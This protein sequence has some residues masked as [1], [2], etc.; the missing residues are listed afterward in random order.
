MGKRASRKDPALQ[1][2][3]RCKK[4]K[5]GAVP[6]A[7]P[8][9][10]LVIL[11]VPKADDGEA[12]GKA[13][14]VEESTID[15]KVERAL[16]NHFSALSWTR[17]LSLTVE[18][19]PLFDR[20][21][22]DWNAKPNGS[23]LGPDYW[24]NIYGKVLGAIEWEP[25]EPSSP[26]LSIAPGLLEG[27][28]LA[29]SRN[30]A[31]R[32]IHCLKTY[33]RCCE[34]ALNEV[35]LCGLLNGYARSVAKSCSLKPEYAVLVATYL[36]RSKVENEWPDYYIKANDILDVGLAAKYNQL[37]RD[38]LSRKAALKLHLDAFT[39][40][41]PHG[42]MLKILDCKD[43]KCDGL[44]HELMTLM[45]A[46]MTGNVAFGMAAAKVEAGMYSYDVDKKMQEFDPRSFTDDELV[47]KL[48]Q[49]LAALVD[50]KKADPSFKPKR[51]YDVVFLGTPFKKTNRDAPSEWEGKFTAAFKDFAVQQAVLA[52]TDDQGPCVALPWEIWAL[53]S[54]ASEHPG[55]P[56]NSRYL[57]ESINVREFLMALLESRQAV[58]FAQ[59]KD[60]VVKKEK[61]L[62]GLDPYWW[63]EQRWMLESC[64]NRIVERVT[65]EI[66]AILPEKEKHVD[67]SIAAN[68][69]H[70]LSLASHVVVANVFKAKARVCVAFGKH[71]ETYERRAPGQTE[72]ARRFYQSAV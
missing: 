14:V 52:G 29:H 32:Q 36:T 50:E 45:K 60:V 47:K 51:E 57:H 53:G 63:L 19:E 37:R 34:R 58:T 10:L 39:T 42:A 5:K 67:I 56:I 7:E 46:S 2:P 16:L 65:C 40:V 13:G 22:R 28:E 35:E 68:A 62:T 72:H 31:E 23:K 44:E 71:A 30:P 4:P 59:M 12:K 55:L 18:A 48:R 1:K 26:N 25:L 8:A 43:E 33:M 6:Q 64:E 70:E 49:D 21:R 41:L 38:G 27:L 15:A 24:D 3:P 20:V 11:P 9:P 61:Q 69:L 66:F 17:I 54:V